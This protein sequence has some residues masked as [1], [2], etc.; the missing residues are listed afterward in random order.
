M[1]ITNKQKIKL[2]TKSFIIVPIGIDVRKDVDDFYTENFRLCLRTEIF[3]SIK[4]SFI[5]KLSMESMQFQQ[6]HQKVY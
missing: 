4:R 2:K 1:L 3:D 6:E 5:P